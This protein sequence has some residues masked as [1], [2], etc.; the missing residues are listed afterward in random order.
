MV[1]LIAGGIGLLYPR[2]VRPAS[3]TL[4]VVYAL[5]SLAC[6]PGIVLAPKVY[7][8]YGSFFEQFSLLC[9]ATAAYASTEV[10]AAQAATLARA[11][12]IGLGFCAVSFTLAQAFYLGFTAQLVP[13]W[14]P[15]NQMFWAIATTIA[16]G[17]AAIAILLNLQ[18]RLAIRLMALM[19][20]LFGVLVWVPLVVAHPQVHGNWS[21]F[22]L[23]FLIA[24]ASWVVADSKPVPRATA[25]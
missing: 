23:T 5:F 14:I 2:T 21:E 9:G 10:Y 17:L 4:I 3:A 15:P 25:R 16:F 11:A 13:K 12:R 7:A 19:I 6:V 18:A 20:T 1:V 24:G 8:A 22:A